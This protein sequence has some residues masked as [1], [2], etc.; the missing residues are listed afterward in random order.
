MGFRAPWFEINPGTADLL[1]RE[2]LSY[3][4]SL[5]SDDVPFLHGNGLVE[6]PGNWMLEDW[7]QFAFNADPA[8]G[9][10]PEDCD[11]VYQLWWQ[12]FLAMRDFGCCFVM[13]LHTWLSGR[14]SR[15]RL[16]ERLFNDIISTGD[17]WFCKGEE[18]ATWVR[19]HPQHRRELTYDRLPDCALPP[20]HFRPGAFSWAPLRRTNS[21]STPNVPAALSK[22]NDLLKS[23]FVRSPSESGRSLIRI[24]IRSRTIS[25]W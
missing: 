19:E 5:M 1:R 16:L 18:L 2:G 14:P 21:P 8:W 7:E 15:V 17:A 11:K 25:R 12:E 13:T 24:T 10:I 22:S 23:G 4:A 20:S 3:N 9:V 6:I